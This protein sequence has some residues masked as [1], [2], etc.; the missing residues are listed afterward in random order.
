MPL[1]NNWPDADSVYPEDPEQQRAILA[2][3]E[4]IRS[5]AERVA[6]VSNLHGMSVRI[7]TDGKY[8]AQFDQEGEKLLAAEL[9]MR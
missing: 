1:P 6:S 4:N 9:T 2:T 3:P 8:Y 7:S 5:V